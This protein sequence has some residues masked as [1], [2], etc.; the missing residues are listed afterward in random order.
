MIILGFIFEV[1]SGIRSADFEVRILWLVIGIEGNCCWIE[2]GIGVGADISEN[3]LTT[4]AVRRSD[5]KF[6]KY[7][8]QA[9]FTLA[10]SRKGLLKNIPDSKPKGEGRER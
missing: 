5:E 6:C 7:T 1:R 9:A 10:E 2:G 8:M 4:I 3:P